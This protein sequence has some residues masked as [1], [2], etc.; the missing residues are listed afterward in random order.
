MYLNIK[1]IYKLEG[2]DIYIL[3]ESLTQITFFTELL[4]NTNTTPDTLM[5]LSCEN[6]PLVKR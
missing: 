1:H 3:H 6:N 5:Q 4:P 2:I